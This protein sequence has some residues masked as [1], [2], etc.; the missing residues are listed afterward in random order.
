MVEFRDVIVLHQLHGEVDGATGNS[1]EQCRLE[2]PCALLDSSRREYMATQPRHELDDDESVLIF[3]GGS[4]DEHHRG[5]G[6]ECR[7]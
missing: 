4:A 1:D 3:H 7:S 5:S 6:N 2:Q